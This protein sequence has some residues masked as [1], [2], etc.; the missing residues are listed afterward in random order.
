MNKNPICR[1][2]GLH[3]VYIDYTMF[4]EIYY[5]DRAIYSCLIFTTTLNYRSFFRHDK[6]K[7][8]RISANN[9]IALYTTTSFLLT[10]V[11]FQRGHLPTTDEPWAVSIYLCTHSAADKKVSEHCLRTVKL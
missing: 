9:V 11:Y 4:A 6:P 3:P 10:S 2:S 8:I 7:R 1:L 5:Y